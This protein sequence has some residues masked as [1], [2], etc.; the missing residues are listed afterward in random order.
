MSK[1]SFLDKFIQRY[2]PET[3]ERVQ[4]IMA[5]SALLE[6]LL[7]RIYDSLEFTVQKY[8]DNFER[9]KDL[10]RLIDAWRLKKYND[11]SLTSIFIGISALVYIVSPIDALPDFI[12][13]IGGLDDVLLLGILLKTL[14][15]EIEKFVEWEKGQ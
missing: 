11:V 12:P 5:S 13:F 9:I 2:Y 8:A 4:A 3:T 10:L 6:N 7:K 14:D 1:T 15:K